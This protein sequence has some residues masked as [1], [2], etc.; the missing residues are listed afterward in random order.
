MQQL[1]PF[2]DDQPGYSPGPETEPANPGTT[3]EPSTAPAEVPQEAPS[4][5][6][7]S[8]T[9]PGTEAPSTPISPVGRS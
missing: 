1:P 2:P 7:P 3:G 8:P 5:D 9:V 4:I 6:V